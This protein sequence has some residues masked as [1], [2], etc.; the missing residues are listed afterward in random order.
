[1]TPSKQTKTS[2]AALAGRR[3]MLMDI[4]DRAPGPAAHPRLRF[5]SAGGWEMSCSGA[6]APHLPG[7]GRPR[8]WVL[9]RATERD[10]VKAA[11]RWR[12]KQEAQAGTTG[13]EEGEPGEESHLGAVTET[14]LAG[15]RGVV[16]PPIAVWYSQSGTYGGVVHSPW[17]TVNPNCIRVRGPTGVRC[18]ASVQ[19]EATP[20]SKSHGISSQGTPG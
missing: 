6:G 14:A 10:G 11:A 7:G 9:S 15:T 5:C 8:M 12:G 17:G 18:D 3:G 1:M 19:K 16:P 4:S 20:A 2:P 13:G